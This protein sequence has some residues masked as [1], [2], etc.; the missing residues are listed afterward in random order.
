MGNIKYYRGVFTKTNGELRT[1]FFVRSGD[2]PETFITSNTKGTGRTRNLKEG[3]ETVWDLQSKSWRTFNWRTSD[4]EE[5]T[6]FEA[7]ENILNNFTN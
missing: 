2:L 6:I 1:M 7:D 5:T 4:P 3:L